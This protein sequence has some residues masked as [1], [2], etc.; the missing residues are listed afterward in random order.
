[1]TGNKFGRPPNCK[2]CKKIDCDCGRPTVMTDE[3]IRRLEAAYSINATDVEACFQA[4]IAP[5]TLY[6]YQ[7]ANPEFVERKKG[8]KSQVSMH[9]KKNVADSIKKGNVRDSWEQLKTVNKKE[10]STQ[11]NNQALDGD[12]DPTDNFIEVRI[13]DPKPQP[14]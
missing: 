1:M 9:A 13:I 6:N 12:G 7:T 14:E 5:A 8:L 10:Y 2:Q 3:V 4:G 11:I